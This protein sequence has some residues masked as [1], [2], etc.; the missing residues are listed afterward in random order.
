M[1]VAVGAA[2]WLLGKVVTQLSDGMVAAYVASTELGL[3]MEQIKT[4][5]AYTQGLLDAA[6]ER[7]VRNNHGLRVLLEILTKQA[8][9]AEDVLDELQYFIIQ[10]Q[11]DGTHEATPMVDDGLRGQVLIHGRHAL[12]HTTGNWLSCFC[13]SSARDDADDPHD[14]PKSHS[15][16]PDHVSK[17]NIQ[18]SRHVQQ[19]QVGDR[20]HTC[21]MYTCIQFAQNYPSCSRKGITTEAT[22]YQLNNYT[23]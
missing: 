21:L 6:E 2:S 16:V 12:H 14:I 7:D 1:D 11:I 19:N 10:D 22:S 18:S 23:G 5:L 3:N 20:G 8:D 4:D 9:E 17:L 15:D 13:C